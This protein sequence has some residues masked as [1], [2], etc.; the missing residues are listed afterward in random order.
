MT[1]ITCPECGTENPDNAMTCKQCGI[2]LKSQYGCGFYGIIVLG[3]VVGAVVGLVVLVF[4][5]VGVFGPIFSPY[6]YDNPSGLFFG[7]I[8]GGAVLGGIGGGV[9]YHLNA[10]EKAIFR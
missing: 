1:T 6:S 5:E 9:L 4:G 2:N 7:C 3:M 8:I 10:L